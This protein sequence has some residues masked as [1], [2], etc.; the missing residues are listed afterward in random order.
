VRRSGDVVVDGAVDARAADAAVDA[1]A[2]LAVRAAARLP[3]G[4][5]WQPVTAELAELRRHLFTTGGCRPP[6][7]IRGG[8]HLDRAFADGGSPTARP[9][10]SCAATRGLTNI[11]WPTYTGQPASTTL[12]LQA[13]ILIRQA[14]DRPVAA[15]SRIV[16]CP[17][18]PPATRPG[19]PPFPGQP[20]PITWPNIIARSRRSSGG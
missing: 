6:G 7:P 15:M 10:T 1:A 18:P 4:C 5:P 8:C 16:D 9:A 2:D 17:P 3:G 20:T 14:P 11:A 13:M 12:E 19:S